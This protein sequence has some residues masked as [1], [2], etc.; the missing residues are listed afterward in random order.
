[1]DFPSLAGTAIDKQGTP[2]DGAQL[3]KTGNIVGSDFLAVFIEN[4]SQ[5]VI[6][7]SSESTTRM[8]V[9]PIKLDHSQD[10]MHMAKIVS[11]PRAAPFKGPVPKEL[12]LGMEPCEEI[13]NG[14][15]PLL[16]P[17]PRSA[18]MK[19]QPVPALIV[20]TD[21]PLQANQTDTSILV[22]PGQAAHVP[23]VTEPKNHHHVICADSQADRPVQRE[24]CLADIP[25][26][27]NVETNEQTPLSSSEVVSS[28]PVVQTRMEQSTHD[29]TPLGSVSNTPTTGVAHE[30]D[31]TEARPAPS[32]TTMLAAELLR[33]NTSAP[34]QVAVG[35]NEAPFVTGA[36][37]PEHSQILADRHSQPVTHI[38]ENRTSVLHLHDP[39]RHVRMVGEA[40]AK[41]TPNGVVEVALDPPELG[42]VTL[43]MTLSDNNMTVIVATDRAE[44]LEMIRR[45]IDMLRA[46]FSAQG[47]SGFDF[48]LRHLPKGGQGHAKDDGTGHSAEKLTEDDVPTVSPMYRDA[49]LG[50]MDIRI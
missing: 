25:P 18:A 9:V 1:M 42:R 4:S 46:E 33:P 28:V 12:E 17:T 10:Q 7:L 48:D 6:S 23:N 5:E 16:Q 15:E 19:T 26:K 24:L 11:N 13:K 32:P 50:R 21:D 38:S 3:S 14:D 31:G 39:Q 47:F 2:E 34:N 35:P 49:L 8:P 41:L 36:E 22:G 43:T 37:I 29:R 30:P 40:L 44:I 27:Q 45:H 20:P